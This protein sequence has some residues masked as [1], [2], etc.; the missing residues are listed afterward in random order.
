MSCLLFR[1]S[2]S[3]LA[4]TRN[5]HSVHI[6]TNRLER[7]KT[8]KAYYWDD[9]DRIQHP[10]D[11]SRSKWHR[12]S[13][14]YKHHPQTYVESESVN[15]GKSDEE[16][17]YRFLVHSHMEGD[18]CRPTLK[19]QFLPGQGNEVP[20]LSEGMLYDPNEPLP[21]PLSHLQ[22]EAQQNLETIP[23]AYTKKL[24]DLYVTLPI[25]KASSNLQPYAQKNLEIIPGSYTNK[26]LIMLLD[27]MLDYLMSLYITMFVPFFRGLFDDKNVH[28]HSIWSRIFCCSSHCGCFM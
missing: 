2:C 7:N 15:E 5:A 21:D 24:H 12:G 14:K 8:T 19:I 18:G 13:Y 25:P 28:L 6:I 11:Y 9:A 10:T 4:G 1:T 22:P 16:R 26:L 27:Q 17:Q 3:N 23:G 20:A